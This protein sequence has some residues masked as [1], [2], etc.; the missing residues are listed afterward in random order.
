MSTP[1]PKVSVCVPSY[2]HSRFLPAALDSILV[3][4]FR[5]FEIVIVDDGSTDDSFAVAQK[6]VADHPSVIRL[7]THP[8]HE[9]RGISATVNL[10]FNNLRGEYWMGL[11][12]DDLLHVDKLERQVKFL[13]D[14]PDYGWVYSYADFIDDDDEPIVELGL[15]GTDITKDDDPVDTLIRRNKIPGMAALMRRDVSARV[16]LHDED[17][18]YSDW[19]YWVRMTAASKVGFISEPLIHYRIHDTNTSLKTDAKTNT[20]RCVFVTQAIQRDIETGAI[21]RNTPRLRALLELQLGYFAFCIDQKD[22]AGSHVARA[23]EVD[24]GLMSDADYIRGWLS[25]WHSFGP[26]LFVTLNKASEFTRWFIEHLP[27]ESSAQVRK[28]IESEL[29]AELAVE[30]LSASPGTARHLAVRSLIKDPGRLSKRE[31][32]R[33]ALAS[34]A[35]NNARKAWKRI[36]G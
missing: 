6:Y 19:H 25:G 3:Q 26:E 4:T 2:N 9:N 30:S 14:N 15:F 18:V 10:A 1:V 7:L 31:L 5:D 8:G 24:P 23:F 34:I 20:Q 27:R 28:R 35:G 22:V 29:L 21:A 16:G 11:P 13:E 17:L 32:R 33:L 12:S 36:K